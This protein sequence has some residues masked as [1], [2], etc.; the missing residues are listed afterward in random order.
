MDR[1]HRLGATERNR[2]AA[3][4]LQTISVGQIQVYMAWRR[5]IGI[6]V[7]SLRHDLHALSP[8]FKYGM[9]VTGVGIIR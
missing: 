4:P 6:K 2:S 3:Q 8:L 7:V 1:K 5:G 9:A